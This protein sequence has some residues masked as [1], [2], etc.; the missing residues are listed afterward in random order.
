MKWAILVASAIALPLM[1]TGCYTPSSSGA[2]YTS[3]QTGREQTVR[4]G[5]V[6]SV[7]QVTI[8]G[9]RGEIGT[10]AG[11][12]VGG[13]AGSD[14]GG[15]KG[16]GVG[17]I[18]GAVVGGVAGSAIERGVTQK[19]GVEVTVRLDNGELR[20]IAQEADEEFRPGER[21]RLV[22]GGGKTRVT[23]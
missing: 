18:L 14:V 13:I 12:A 4:M 2:V 15:G 11:G 16:S 23:H 1:L 19:K 22:T 20:A 3:G 7:R 17:T 21:V 6:E 9:T 5:V 10:L 8:E